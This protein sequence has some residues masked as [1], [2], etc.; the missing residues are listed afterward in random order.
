MAYLSRAVLEPWQFNFVALLRHLA[1]RHPELPPIG[2][3]LLPQQENFRLGQSPSLLFAPREIDS[4]DFVDGLPRIRLFGLGMLGPNGPLPIHFTEIAKDR[5]DNRRDPTLV[6]FLDIFHHR[7]LSILY[8]AWAA[9]QST[10]GLDRSNDERFSRYIAWLS[11]HEPDEIADSPLP[12]HAR[13]AASPHLVR[14][15]RNPDGLAFTLSFFLG[16]NVCLQEFIPR[17]IDVEEQERSV[18][19]HPAL[20]SVLGEGAM[21]GEVIPDR[22]HA[23]RLVVGPLMLSEYLRFIPVGKDLPLVL[24]WVRGFIGFEYHW[25]IQLDIHSHQAPMAQLGADNRLGWS[26]WLG[27]EHPLPATTGMVFEPECYIGIEQGTRM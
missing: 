11:G 7:Y 12:A 21:L 26:T 15:A 2:E 10:A 5:E 14:E 17:W 25:E 8:R 6:N 1:A 18:L 27:D 13:L 4:V 23:F 16:V 9:A 20:S 22:Q 24:E 3:T 19:G